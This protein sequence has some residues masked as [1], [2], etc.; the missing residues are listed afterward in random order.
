MSGSEWRFSL[1]DAHTG[2]RHGF[3]SLSEL[4]KFLEEQMSES[5]REPGGGRSYPEEDG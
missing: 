2:Q 4:M 5:D 3:G 1:Q